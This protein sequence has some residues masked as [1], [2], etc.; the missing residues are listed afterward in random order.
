MRLAPAKRPVLG[1][2]LNK[3]D[4]NVV[5]PQPRLLRQ[6]FGDARKQAALLLK[7]ARI[8]HGQLNDGQIVGVV[9]ILLGDDLEQILFRDTKVSTRAEWTPCETARRNSGDLPLGIAMRT[10]GMGDLD[11]PLTL[12]KS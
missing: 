9:G 3:V 8:A 2:D 1:L 4:E 6:P 5:R 7:A 11:K 10:S 12:P